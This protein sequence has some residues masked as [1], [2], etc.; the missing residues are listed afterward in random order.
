MLGSNKANRAKD[1]SISMLNQIH[2]AWDE[3][4]YCEMDFFLCGKSH[5][6][7]CMSCI[8]DDFG[9]HMFVTWYLMVKEGHLTIQLEVILYVFERQIW[10]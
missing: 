4:M 9:H 3:E 8:D 2:K 7:L 6:I 5:F 10:N 1:E